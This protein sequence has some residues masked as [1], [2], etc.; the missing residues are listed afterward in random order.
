MTIMITGGAGFIGSHTCV[1]LMR[2]GHA[3]VIYD[4]LCNSDREV[5]N[6]IERITG[7]RPAFVEG[8]IRDQDRLAAVLSEYGCEAVIHF[9]GLK[10]VAESVTAAAKYYDN[11]VAGALRLVCAMQQAGVRNLVFSSSATV[12]GEPVT[13][14]LS[15]SHRRSPFSPYGRTKM[16]VEDMLVDVAL[17]ADPLNV[18]ILRYFNPVGAHESGLMGEDPQGDPNNLMP[19]VSQVAV[20][21]RPFLNIF[22]NDY[23]TPDGTCIR[24][25][26]HVMDLAAGH[27]RAL[28]ALDRANLITVNLGT[29]QG[30]SVLELV[31]AFQ[32]ASGRKIPMEIA[33]RRSGDVAQYYASPELA[34]TMLGWSAERSLADMCRDAW[35]W[36]SGNPAGYRGA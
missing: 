16:A 33:A 23:P 34:R 1:E 36:Q 6:R 27:L 17:S 3:V 31:H 12:Y 21:R 15:E 10:S 29:G 28:E 11:N 5:L 9:A 18:A 25:Y 19:F 20:G 13:L 35:K 8:D 32:K 7:V 14:P 22:G 4:N 24:D 30:S 26:V 2:G